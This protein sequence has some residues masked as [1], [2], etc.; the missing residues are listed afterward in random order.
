MCRPSV[1][2][3]VRITLLNKHTQIIYHYKP[4]KQQICILLFWGM[5]QN[6]A[7]FKY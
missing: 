3:N 6:T 5:K 7:K 1:K 2:K 4:G